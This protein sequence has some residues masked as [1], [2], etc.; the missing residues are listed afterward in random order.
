VTSLWLDISRSPPEWRQGARN[1]FAVVTSQLV[2]REAGFGDP[3][4]A[5]ERLARLEELPLLEITDEALTLSQQFLQTGAIP[6]AFPEDALQVAV[7][8]VNGIEY[9]LTWNYKHLPNGLMRSKIEAVWREAG[10][11][12]VI[13]CT[14]EELAEE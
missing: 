8:V 6:L 3:E 13:I 9:L 5:Q 11:E 2:L 1:A 10:Y 12:P 7:A 14:P 4:A